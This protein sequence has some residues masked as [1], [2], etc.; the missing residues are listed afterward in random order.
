MRPAAALVLVAGLLS[1]C[2]TIQPTRPAPALRLTVQA[3]DATRARLTL[4]PAPARARWQVQPSQLC[5]GE[6]GPPVAAGDWPAPA[7]PLTVPA[8]AGDLVTVAATL[9]DGTSATAADCPN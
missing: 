1:A 5:G 8:R 7:Q 6:D 3:L 2:S 9:P 4:A